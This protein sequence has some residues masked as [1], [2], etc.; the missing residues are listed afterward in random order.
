VATD[1]V[2][3]GKYRVEGLVSG[4]CTDTDGTM[5]DYSDLVEPA[6]DEVTITC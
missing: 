3:R 4:T 6:S 5:K 1:S 2:M